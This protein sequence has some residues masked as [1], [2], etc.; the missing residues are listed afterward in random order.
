MVNKTI[1]MSRT[2][3]RKHEGREKPS[4][5]GKSTEPANQTETE[6]EDK[7]DSEDT[8]TGENPKHDNKVQVEEEK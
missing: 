1:R 8:T 5:H 4:E 2:I 6:L 3:M 7:N